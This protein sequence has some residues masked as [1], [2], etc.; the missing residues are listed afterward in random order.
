MYRYAIC[1]NLGK[2]KVALETRL[3]WSSYQYNFTFCESDMI[4]SPSVHWCCG[5]SGQPGGTWGVHTVYLQSLL[6]GQSHWALLDPG[7][8][9]T[10]KNTTLPLVGHPVPDITV[11]CFSWR[12]NSGMITCVYSKSSWAVGNVL[13]PLNTFLCYIAVGYL[14]SI[15]G[16]WMPLCAHSVLCMPNKGEFCKHDGCREHF[17]CASTSALV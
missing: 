3:L 1:Y 4:N 8:N 2:Q 12:K 11:T 5:T 7:E 9:P 17:C 13:L 14:T 10:V 15:L 6:L 16:L